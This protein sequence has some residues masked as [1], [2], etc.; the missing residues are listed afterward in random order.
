MASHPPHTTVGQVFAAN[1][2]SADIF[3]RSLALQG[4]SAAVGLLA[5]RIL[6]SFLFQKELVGS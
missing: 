2:V 1:P 5:Y 3:V 4:L 6:R